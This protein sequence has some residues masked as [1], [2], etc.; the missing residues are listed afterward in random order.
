METNDKIITTAMYGYIESNDRLSTEQKGCR[1]ESWGTKDKLL[2]DKTALN[3]CMKRHTNLAMVW[4]DYKET[5]D[6]IPYSW[7]IESLKFINVA[8]NVIKFIERS[9]MSW[10]VNLS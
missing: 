2:I 7:I 6:M 3:D 1:K 9:M 4:V 8:D 5:Y 10:N